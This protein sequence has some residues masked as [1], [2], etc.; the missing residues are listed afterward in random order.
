MGTAYAQAVNACLTW[1]EGDL[2]DI[3]GLVGD[4]PEELEFES[5]IVK[6]LLD[7]RI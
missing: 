5:A 3:Y 4:T 7:V 6:P 2:G 1:L